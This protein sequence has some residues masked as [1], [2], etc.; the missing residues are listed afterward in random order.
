MPGVQTLVPLLLDHVAAGRM[1]LERFVDLTAHGPPADLPDRRQGAHRGGLRRRLHRGRPEGPAGP[2]PATG[3]PRSAAGRPSKTWRSPAGPVMTLVRGHTVMRDDELL[4]SPV[5]A[6][7]RFQETFA[8]R[9]GRPVI[10]DRL[11]PLLNVEDVEASLDF[12][13]N[14]LGF[15]VDNRHDDRGKPIWAAIRHGE[16]ALMLNSPRAGRQQRP[17]A[18]AEL[19]R[20]AVLP[21]RPRRP[22][23]ARGAERAGLRARPA[24]GNSPTACWSSPCAI[25]TATSWPSPASSGRRRKAPSPTRRRGLA[26]SGAR[27]NDGARPGRPCRAPWCGRRR[28]VIWEGACRRAKPAAPTSGRET[29]Q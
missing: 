26:S 23:G 12:Y 1:T 7:V 21:L 14:A 29:R 16:I 2:S 19:R 20:D 24:G 27:A 3:W 18:P 5:G 25:R 9:G 17:P 4:D 13:R 11:V 15:T 22:G 6:P 10:L 8:P 28:A